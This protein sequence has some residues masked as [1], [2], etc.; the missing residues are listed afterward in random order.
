MFLQQ[1]AWSALPQQEPCPGSNFLVTAFVPRHHDQGNSFLFFLFFK[2]FN[3]GLAYISEAL[4]IIKH[5]ARHGARDVAETCI[6]THRQ[7]EGEAVGES[8]G[9][10]M[11]FWNFNAHPQWHSYC[12]KATPTPIMSHLQILSNSTIPWQLS[13]QI[14]EP[15]LFK[16][17]HIV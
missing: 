3:W 1:T 5:G 9:P 17:T 10:A 13:I 11:G 7:R 4:S 15:F 6:L 12:N 14:Y 16:P 8:L 2:A